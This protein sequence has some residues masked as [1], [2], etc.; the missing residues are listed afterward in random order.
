MGCHALGLVMRGNDYRS[1]APQSAHGG[2]YRVS[3]VGQAGIEGEVIKQAELQVEV[4]L[5][6]MSYGSSFTVIVVG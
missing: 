6:A 2:G 3:S 5:D 4:K 1:S